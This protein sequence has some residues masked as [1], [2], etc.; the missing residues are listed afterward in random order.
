MAQTITVKMKG[1]SNYYFVD[2]TETDQG[3]AGN[4]LSVKDIVDSVGTTKNATMVFG[5]TGTGNTTTYSFGT[6]ETIP[7]NLSIIVEAGAII[8]VATGITVTINAP[9]TANER[10]KCISLTGTGVIDFGEESISTVYPEWWGATID[11]GI[12][13]STAI[14][15]AVAAITKGIVKFGPGRYDTATTR[16]NVYG[17]GKSLIGSGIAATEI[18][19][20][21]DYEGP[22][23]R[24]GNVDGTLA[25]G[26]SV[27]DMKLSRD[28]GAPPNGAMGLQGAMFANCRAKNL[29]ITNHKYCL[30]FRSETGFTNASRGFVVESCFIEEANSA[31]VHISDAIGITF[32]DCTFGAGGKL[33]TE[34]L[35]VDYCV[36]IQDEADKIKFV[37]CNFLPSDASAATTTTAIYLGTYTG[38]GAIIQLISCIIDGVTDATNFAAAEDVD[39]ILVG[40]YIED[41]IKINGSSAN[42][43]IVGN[44]LTTAPT[45]TGTYTDR[46]VGLNTGGD[47]VD[48]NAW[49]PAEIAAGSYAAVAWTDVTGVELGDYLLYSAEVDLQNMILHCAI[50]ADD[51]VECNLY[52]NTAGA[53]DLGSFNVNLRIIKENT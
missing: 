43:T 13:A 22:V 44:Q 18:Q 6:N 8:S 17:T 3:V 10:T 20:D 2:A 48:V 28:T 19:V 9:F 41:N 29:H 51:E 7:S 53:I 45:M 39:L 15:A 34:S 25:T 24:F 23:I 4:G 49:N 40:C 21:G 32:S 31:Y 42:V 14:N 11:T 27:E 50:R 47:I 35:S 38:T 46:V 36:L 30:E 26:C 16:I 1:N 33:G 37:N 52:N 5:H 12:D